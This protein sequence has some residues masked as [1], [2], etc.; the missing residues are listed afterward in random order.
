MKLNASKVLILIVGFI[1]IIGINTEYTFD[2]FERC[3]H[4]TPDSIDDCTQHQTET[5]SCC[6]FQY[7]SVKG[8]VM[9]GKRY[10]GGTV[11][12]GMNFICKG[13]FISRIQLVIILLL[14]GLIF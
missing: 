3:F 12:G 7:G 10:L 14:F 1:L 8:C 5:S 2:I 13:E 6:Y 11:Y 4:G 9:L